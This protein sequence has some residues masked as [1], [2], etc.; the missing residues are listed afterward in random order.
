M[1][2]CQRQVIITVADKRARIL[3]ELMTELNVN[4]NDHHKI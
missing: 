1:M 2:G 4:R 3:I